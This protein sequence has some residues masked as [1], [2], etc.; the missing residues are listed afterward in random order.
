MPGEVLEG[1]CEKLVMA[2]LRSMDIDELEDLK[3]MI[4]M[5]MK[6]DTG[7]SRSKLG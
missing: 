6:P 4:L 2:I 1:E 3:A 5:E 7:L